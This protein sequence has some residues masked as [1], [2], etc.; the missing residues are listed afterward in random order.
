MKHIKFLF[1]IVILLAVII[2]TV[3]NHNAFSETV[4]F[5]VNLLYEQYQT[6]ETSIYLISLIA[7]MLGVL[8]TWVYGL[9]ERFQMKRR[10]ASLSNEID[11]KDKEL[12][13]LRNLPIT[14]DSV[15]PNS[16]DDYV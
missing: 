8:I 2:L 14:T 15:L 4:R 1:L 5:R 10:I 12:N 11:E 3:Q 7:F 16:Q 6:A 9:M 13:S